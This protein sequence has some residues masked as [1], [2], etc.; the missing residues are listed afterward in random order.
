MF[1]GIF[2][3]LVVLARPCSYKAN[4][5]GVTYAPLSILRCIKLI[6]SPD[7]STQSV[8]S[9]LEPVKRVNIGSGCRIRDLGQVCDNRPLVTVRSNILVRR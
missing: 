5:R 4:G 2:T 7:T 9:D 6:D 8:L 1:E 3:C